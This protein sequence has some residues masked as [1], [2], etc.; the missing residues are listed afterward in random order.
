MRVLSF[1]ALLLCC[2]I[3]TLAGVIKG[4]VTDTKGEALPYATVYIDGTTIGTT[5]NGAG[6]YE[7]AVQPGTYKIACQYVGYRQ[8]SFTVTVSG[9][10]AHVHDMKLAEEALEMKEVVIKATDEDPA[11]RIIRNTIAR[12]KFHLDQVRSFQA[13]IYFKGVMRSRRLPDK[14]MG[15]TIKSADLGVD[16][17]GKGVLYLTEEEADYYS[18]GEKE[19]TIIHAVH[20]SGNKSGLGFS[21][22]PP[23][24]TFY[25]NNVSMLGRGTRGFI[26]PISDNALLYYKYKLLGTFEEHGRTIYKIQVSQRRA[27]EPCFSGTIYITDEEWGIHSLDMLLEKRSGMDMIDTLAIQQVF[28]P[29]QKDSWVIKSQVLYFTVKFMMFDVTGSGVAVYN[30]QKVNEP[31]PDSI[32]GGKITSQYDKTANKKDSTHWDARPVPLEKDEQRDFVVKD[33]INTIVNSPAYRDSVRRKG[34]KFKPV[35]HLLSEP[36][37]SS[38]EYRNTYT[39]N[40]VL[41]GLAETSMLNFNTVE[42]FNLAPKMM[43]RHRVDSS[44]SLNMEVALRYGFSNERFNG[45]GR[46]YYYKRDRT[47]LNRAW[48]YG[49]DAGRY[50]FQYN[51]DNPVIPML[52]TWRALGAR[53]NDLK[54][55]ERTEATAYVRRN[56]GN[57]LQWMLRASWQQRTPLENTTSYSLA[58]SD[59]GGYTPN[60]PASL[61]AV[62]TAWEQH[63]AAIVKATISY[64][65]G[66]TYT[67]YPDHKVANGSSWPRFTLQY[68]KGIAGILNS[69]TDYDKWRF[70][71]RDDLNLRLF[72]SFSY[73]FAIGGFLNTRYVSFPDLMHIQGMRGTGYAAPYLQSFQ[74]APYYAFSNTAPLY[75]EG[76]VEYHLNGLLSNKIPLLRQARYYLLVGGNALYINNSSYYTEAFVGIDNI[77][78][79][80]MRLMRVD[81]VQ[82]WDSNMGRNSGIRVGLTMRG[83]SVVRNNPTDGEW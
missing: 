25:E 16:T 70:S 79:K 67:Q 71:I 72:G 78:W 64:K 14:F 33:S 35:A 80:L 37:Y 24:I 77:G 28:V 48:I 69:K 82:S 8:S 75:G 59:K 42:G 38:K 34:N 3:T 7:L 21:Q 17:A 47:W 83:V 9:S 81:F 50:V 73:H 56:Y 52:N 2:A 5:T 43:V 60:T 27:Y 46:V 29:M 62:A 36:S 6:Y 22:F 74:F 23:V 11:Y 40:S 18:E 15:Q 12:R 41:L 4:K 26:S 19:K 68:T 61:L 10:E 30:R 1:I 76:H 32:F 65:P 53:E 66:F 58:K 54:I 49:A 55:Y 39:F 13:S 44:S 51:P 20:E 31:I 57:G 45:I 63:D